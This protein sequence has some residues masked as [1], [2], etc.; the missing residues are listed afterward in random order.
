MAK[1]RNKAERR[2]KRAGA[3]PRPWNARQRLERAE[4]TD[5]MLTRWLL[6]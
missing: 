2:K 3:K 4:G 5:A 1:R 6:V